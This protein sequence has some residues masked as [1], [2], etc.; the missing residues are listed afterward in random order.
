M[1]M[2]FIFIGNRKKN[3]L[4]ISLLNKHQIMDDQTTMV[5]SIV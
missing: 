2:S 1:L 3:S 4:L 5:V